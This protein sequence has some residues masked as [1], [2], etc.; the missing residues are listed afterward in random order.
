MRKRSFI[1]TLVLLTQSSLALTAQAPDVSPSE[2]P[3]LDELREVLT[4]QQELLDKQDK[5]LE[6]QSDLISRQQEDLET[7]RQ[8]LRALQTQVDQLGLAQ[9]PAPSQTKEQVESREQL[10]ADK[11][12]VD[13]SIPANVLRAGDFPGSIHLPGTNLNAKV[14]GFVR[15]GSVTSL[16]PIGSDD[17]F[18]VGSI[19]MEGEATAEDEP[20]STISAKRSRV[21]MD[22]RMDSSV[23]QFRAFVEGDFAGDGG[24]ENYRLRHAFGQ[25]NK[26]LL[27]QTWST[28]MDLAAD[29]EEVDFEGLSGQIN[30]RHPL[31]RWAGLGLVG[32]NWAFGLEDPQ[33]SYTGGT[34]VSEFWDIT[35]STSWG[36]PR[37]HVQLGMLFRNL[38]GRATLEDGTNGEQDEAFGYG[39]SV[40][41]SSLI[42]RRNDMDNIKWQLNAGKGIGNYINDLR[43]VG[44]QD[45]V[46][47]PETG[48]LE[49]LPVL[50]GYVAYQR[51]WRPL[52]SRFFQSMR[53]TY[54]YSYVYVDNH[55]FQSGDAYKA[56]Q[57]ATAN[58]IFS[59]IS[60]LDLG[61]EILW[62]S[63]RD[64]DNQTGEAFQ[65]QVVATFRF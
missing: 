39:L 56:T 43:S 40:S 65:W 16:D 55:T 60:S 24:T 8:A 41:G 53:S 3:T 57:R 48:E 36:R 1:L 54:V 46:F 49:A 2:A 20:R 10:A 58:F 38:N 7:Q 61:A 21:N 25:Y 28:L 44:G 34:G 37:G 52:K 59:P 64:K 18:I 11:A 42:A 5:E 47:D 13:E 29:P 50:S 9:G 6:R 51:Y 62:G 33:P 14:G 22:V 32:R 31:M 17:R 23:G 4:A 15:L 27:G 19:P 63:R 35:T 30:V 45:G 12:T 26:L